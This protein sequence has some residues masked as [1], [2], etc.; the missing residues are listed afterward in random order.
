MQ[1]TTYSFK[2][3]SRLGGELKTGR[4][5]GCYQ[6]QWCSSIESQYSH[7]IS[8]K[9]LFNQLGYESYFKVYFLLQVSLKNEWLCCQLFT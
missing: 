8:G 2:V 5:K 7:R 6:I 9:Y 3:L 1:T 4:E